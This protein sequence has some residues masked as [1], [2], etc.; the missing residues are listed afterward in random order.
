LS[1]GG[2]TY[3]V[4]GASFGG[5]LQGNKNLEWCVRDN[6]EEVGRVE[7]GLIIE[8]GKANVD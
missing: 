8:G 1:G 5:A 4:F 7:K 6:E 3:E 2:F